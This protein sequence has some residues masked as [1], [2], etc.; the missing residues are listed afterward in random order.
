MTPRLVLV[1]GDQLTPSV[2]ALRHAD[3][4]RDVVVMAEVMA[5]A[6][7]VPHHPQKIALIFAAMRHFAQALRDDGWRVAYTRLDDPANTQSIPGELIR[8]AAA[9]GATAV[10]ATSPGDWRLI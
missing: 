6:G 10:L 3:K 1:L 8:Q 4:A 2:A 7:A 9:T 5:E